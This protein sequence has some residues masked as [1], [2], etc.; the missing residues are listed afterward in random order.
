MKTSSR[1]ALIFIGCSLIAILLASLFQR[2]SH[3]SLTV[4]KFSAAQSA[5]A[6]TGMEEIG[7]LM[8]V[9]AKNPG[10]SIST[11]RLVEALMAAGQWQGAEN[12]AQKAL[13]MDLPAGQ[14]QRAMYLLAVIH[15]NQGNHSQAAE[16]LE[17]LLEKA[18]LPSARYS[19]GILYLHFLNKPEAGRE[20]LRKGLQIKGISPGLEAAMREELEKADETSTTQQASE[21]RPG[22]GQPEKKDQLETAP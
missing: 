18:E 4:N 2:F 16:L 14:A 12:F 13:A 15:H 21:E 11:L 22:G 10:D 5:P 19:L 20:Q 9:V 8:Q 3:P 17:K 7:Q 6:P 1:I